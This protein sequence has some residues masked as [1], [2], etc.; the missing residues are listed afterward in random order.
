M[1]LTAP[2]LWAAACP[3]SCVAQA[4]TSE[5]DVI[6]EADPR[7]LQVGILLRKR[8]RLGAPCYGCPPR[9]L[10]NAA[11][12]PLPSRLRLRLPFLSL[13]RN[14][15]LKQF[16][17]IPMADLEM[18]MP[19]KKV[20][21]HSQAGKRAGAQ[22]GLAVAGSISHSILVV[23]AARTWARRCWVP[24]VAR[25]LLPEGPGHACMPEPALESLG[26]PQT[27]PNCAHPCPPACLPAR[28]PARPQVFVP[29]KVFVEMAVTLIGGLA[30]MLSGG[31]KRWSQTVPGG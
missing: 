31:L 1:L 10:S 20:S 11:P 29:P 8:M 26:E 13:Q 23:G 16:R 9:Q 30:A 7:F 27:S 14:I 22:T 18:I 2:L 17:G 12:R 19:E 21:R 25:R 24:D 5:V 4:P 15:V 28:P 6:Q 3:C